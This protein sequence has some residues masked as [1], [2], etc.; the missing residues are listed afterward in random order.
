MRKKRIIPILLVVVLALGLIF[1][2]ASNSLADSV[3]V[4]AP[5][6]GAGTADVVVQELT[7]DALK[8]VTAVVLLAIGVAGTWATAKI[9]QGKH[10]DN[11]A[12]ATGLLTAA[13]Q[14]TVGELNQTLAERYKADSL[15]GKLSDFQIG[16]LGKELLT[17]TKRKLA[18]PVVDLLEA[19]KTDVNAAIKG[20]AESYIGE[21]HDPPA[22]LLED[23]LA[24]YRLQ[25]GRS[26]G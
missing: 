20:A 8:I 24:E 16:Q 14:E 4:N 6:A 22:P 21:L 18:A 25:E 11:I 12:T 2:L 7:A 15:D 3:S 13:A 26:D 1:I 23:I 10:L 17:L 9:A 5:A 19:A